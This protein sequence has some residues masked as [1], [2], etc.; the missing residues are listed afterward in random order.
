MRIW[1][2]K[3]ELNVQQRIIVDNKE[4]KSRPKKGNAVVMILYNT[5]TLNFVT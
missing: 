3:Y 4:M 1:N 2:Q 5:E